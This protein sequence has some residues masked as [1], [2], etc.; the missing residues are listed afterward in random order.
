MKHGVE[1]VNRIMKHSVV[2]NEA[3]S[4]LSRIQTTEGLKAGD[5]EL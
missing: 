5:H 1:A 2:V 4:N 3:R